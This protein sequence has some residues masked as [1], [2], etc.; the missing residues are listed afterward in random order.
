VL[1]QAQMKKLGMGAPAGRGRRGSRQPPKLIVM[2]YR[3]GRGKDQKP[4]VLV[5]KGITL[6]QPAA[7]PSSRPSPWTR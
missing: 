5:G 2:E 4:H 3:G 7:S 6:R 1:D